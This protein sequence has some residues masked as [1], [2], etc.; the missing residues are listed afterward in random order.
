MDPIHSKLASLPWLLQSGSDP[1][2]LLHCNWH[3]LAHWIIAL[4]L[5]AME[6]ML[7]LL[8]SYFSFSIGDTAWIISGVI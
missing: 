5:D 4:E 8:T 2:P 7:P 1:W 6:V 3:E